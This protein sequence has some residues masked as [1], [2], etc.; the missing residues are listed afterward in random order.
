MAEKRFVRRE[1]GRTR[2]RRHC[3]GSDGRKEKGREKVH[4]NVLCRI[5]ERREL[6]KGDKRDL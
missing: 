1:G 2:T 4:V 3:G 5:G 6:C